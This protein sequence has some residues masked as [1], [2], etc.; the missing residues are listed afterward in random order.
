M[1]DCKRP[2]GSQHPSQDLVAE[3]RRDHENDLRAPVS[4]GDDSPHR[5][6]AAIVRAAA[7]RILPL[8]ALVLISIVVFA[9]AAISGLSLAGLRAL[10]LWRTFSGFR[11]RLE[12]ELDEAASRFAATERRLDGA[13][14]DA[15]RLDDARAR[16][17]DSLARLG[18]LARA[19]AETAA[20]VRRVRGVVP[21]K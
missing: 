6:H 14:G 13:S 8:H 21:S 17:Q 16:L 10:S 4:S 19:A 1:P 20:L 2:V 9:L 15:Q 18:V 5:C 11:R 3:S 12:A 7:T